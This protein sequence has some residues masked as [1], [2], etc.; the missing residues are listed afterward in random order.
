M[1]KNEIIFWGTRR[2]IHRVFTQGDEWK[3]LWVNNHISCF[4]KQ[5]DKLWISILNDIQTFDSEECCVR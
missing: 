5:E 3:E 1:T 4:I 2:G